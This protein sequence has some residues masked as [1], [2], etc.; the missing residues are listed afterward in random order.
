V[1]NAATLEAVNKVFRRMTRDDD[2]LRIQ[3]LDR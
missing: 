2:N 1:S 3:I